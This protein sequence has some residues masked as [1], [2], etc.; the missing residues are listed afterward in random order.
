MQV[1]SL[2]SAC[3]LVMTRRVMETTWLTVRR[4]TQRRSPLTRRR[5]L[6]WA[7]G[8]R[9]W[10]FSETSQRSIDCCGIINLQRP[11][12]GGRE[13]RVEQPQ[14]PEMQQRECRKRERWSRCV[15]VLLASSAVKPQNT[16]VCVLCLYPTRT[17]LCLCSALCSSVAVQDR[18]R[19]GLVLS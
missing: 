11:A 6:P 2:T 1:S 9:W 15:I 14:S 3:G 12:V 13:A 16:A 8:L 17:S 4:P 5:W 10:Q 19:V 18:R 7:P